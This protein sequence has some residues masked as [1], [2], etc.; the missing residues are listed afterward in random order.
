VISGV[1]KREKHDV[2][3]ATSQ[4]LPRRRRPPPL[5]KGPLVVSRATP[6]QWCPRRRPGPSRLRIDPAAWRGPG[7]LGLCSDSEGQ[8][9]A[10]CCQRQR[11]HQPERT[12]VSSLLLNRHVEVAG[13]G[14]RRGL[15]FHLSRLDR[16]FC[17]RVLLVASS[18]NCK[19]RGRVLVQALSSSLPV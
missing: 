5:I 2:L 18:W 8:L 15:E 12:A 13:A 6:G 11:G 7:D 9:E 17:L 16:G 10:R 19:P 3:I 1:L 4:A 14:W